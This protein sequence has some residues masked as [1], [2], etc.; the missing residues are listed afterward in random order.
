MASHS[1]ASSA[2]TFLARIAPESQAHVLFEHLPG[3]CFFLKNRRSELVKANPSFLERLGLHS[4]SELVG[5]TDYDLF[6]RQLAE[7]FRRDDR[8]VMELGQPLINRVELFI[9]RQ[10]IPDWYV[11]TKVP[12]RDRAG[13]IIGVMGTVQGSGDKHGI[14]QPHLPISRAVEYIRTRFREPISIREL[15][16]MVGLSSRQFD[17]R[18]KEVFQVTPQQFVI[19]MRIQA[20]CRALRQPHRGIGDVAAETGFYDQSSFT[21]HFRKHMGITPL[22]Y[23]NL[24]GSQ[25]MD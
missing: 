2:E 4:E 5:K 17:R 10:G 11:T 24:F 13:K 23:R 20:A 16:R 8:R 18:F 22:R 9:N 21:R 12:V 25:A 3:I 14:L 1:S 19:K 7:N 15:A 6:P